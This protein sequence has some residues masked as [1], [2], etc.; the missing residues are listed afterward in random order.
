M[1]TS[2]EPLTGFPTCLSAVAEIQRDVVGRGKQGGL[3]PGFRKKDESAIAAWRQDINR[4]LHIFN[5]RSV[6]SI[7]Q[8]LITSLLDGAVDE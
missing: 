6:G 4:I 8:L 5:V 1:H 7:L 2:C 3:F